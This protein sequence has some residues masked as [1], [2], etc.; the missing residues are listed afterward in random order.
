MLCFVGVCT[1]TCTSITA[2]HCQC[3]CSTVAS[4]SDD[5]DDDVVVDD[6]NIDVLQKTADELSAKTGS[7]V[8]CVL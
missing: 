7:K 8:L 1:L 4:L 6:R 3:I 5:D 2:V